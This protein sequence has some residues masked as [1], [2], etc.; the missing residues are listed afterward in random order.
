ML[1]KNRTHLFYQTHVND[2]D[3]SSPFSLSS[4]NLLEVA[5]GAGVE[6]GGL[7]EVHVFGE[8]LVD[9]CRHAL[10]KFLFHLLGEVEDRCFRLS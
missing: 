5:V 6:V 1:E 8:H 4:A 2:Q 7:R 9:D 3:M 10:V